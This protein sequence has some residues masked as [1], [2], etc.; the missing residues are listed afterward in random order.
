M[1]KSLFTKYQKYTAMFNCNLVHTVVY[2]KQVTFYKI[3]ET[4]DHVYLVGLYLTGQFSEELCEDEAG[5]VGGE[6]VEQLPVPGVQ[7]PTH[8]GHE[9]GRSDTVPKCK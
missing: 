5:H 6:D 4:R 2:T 3:P 9:P 8:L 7:L 1:D